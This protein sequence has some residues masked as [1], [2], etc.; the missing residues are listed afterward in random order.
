MMNQMQNR[1]R[2]VGVGLDFYLLD[3][4]R[5]HDVK[6]VYGYFVEFVDID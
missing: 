6:G 3:F 4:L 1:I 2:K 5:S